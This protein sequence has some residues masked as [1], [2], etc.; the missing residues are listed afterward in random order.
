MNVY[1]RQCID[2]LQRYTTNLFHYNYRICEYNH[3]LLSTSMLRTYHNTTI[4]IIHMCVYSCNANVKSVLG[5]LEPKT[6]PLCTF[7]IPPGQTCGSKQPPPLRLLA[8]LDSWGGGS[9]E[10]YLNNNALCKFTNAI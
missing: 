1:S 5:Q 4:C 6:R 7:N 9:L 2:R 8:A 10:F 3:Q